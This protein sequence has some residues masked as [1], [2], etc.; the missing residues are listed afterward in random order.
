M[1]NP[2][3]SSEQ[4]LK[5]EAERAKRRMIDDLN[6]MTVMEETGAEGHV[7]E[8]FDGPRVKKFTV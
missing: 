4:A 6:K 3:A 8:E 5:E 2:N 1:Q 7:N